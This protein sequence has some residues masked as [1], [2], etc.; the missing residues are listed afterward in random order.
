MIIR[1][2][3]ACLTPTLFVIPANSIGAMA[4]AESIDAIKGPA[5]PALSVT[6]SIDSRGTPERRHV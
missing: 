6:F 3:D 4:I 1:S 2:K 5:K